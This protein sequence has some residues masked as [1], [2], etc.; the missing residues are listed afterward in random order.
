MKQKRTA[1]SNGRFPAP[2]F[3]F[4]W[5]VTTV[6]LINIGINLTQPLAYYLTRLGVDSSLAM[7]APNFLI[8]FGLLVLA[9]A[10]LL[11]LYT[12]WSTWRWLLWSMAG[13]VGICIMEVVYVNTGLFR[14]SSPLNSL[15][16]YFILFPLGLAQWW[17]IRDRV[18][19]DWLLPLAYPVAFLAS[20]QVYN[21]LYP[22]YSSMPSRYN[23]FVGLTVFVLVIGLTLTYLIRSQPVPVMAQAAP[24]AKH[25]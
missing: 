23:D 3:L 22:I 10:V 21:L 15:F 16:Y 9:Q 7:Y 6:I 1:A 4:V 13:V 14:V 19:H 24:K 25:E 8:P 2:V 5:V 17:V 20:E 12:G 18:R 11:N